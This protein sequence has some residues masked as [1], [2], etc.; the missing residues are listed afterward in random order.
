MSGV[1][2]VD[3]GLTVRVEFKLA[4][5]SKT[6]DQARM[7]IATELYKTEHETLK[8]TFRGASDE[9]QSSEGQTTQRTGRRTQQQPRGR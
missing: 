5:E 9:R 8:K 3:T 4:A 1:I 7:E 6:L 2:E